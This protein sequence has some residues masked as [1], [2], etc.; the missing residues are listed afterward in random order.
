[1]QFAQ[2]NEFLQYVTGRTAARLE[3]PNARDTV[4]V[5]MDDR[6]LPLES[7][8]TGI[9]EVVIL[10][11][12]ATL[13][14]GE[15]VCIE[16]P[17]IHLHPVLQRKLLQ[18]LEEKTENQYLIA[19]H[20]AHLLDHPGAAVFH[21]R[22]EDRCSHVRPA[23]SPSERSEI[24]VDLG[25]RASDLLQANCVIWVE[26]PS[27]RIYLAH[28]LEAEAPHLREGVHYSIMF[29]GGRLLS[30]LTAE[31]PEVNEFISLRRL[32]RFIAVLMDS[33]RRTRWTELSDTKKRM[34]SEF[35][36]GPGFAWVTRGREIENYIPHS[37]LE[38]AVRACHRGV[39]EVGDT[40]EFRRALRYRAGRRKWQVADKVKV[41]HF[42]AS[43]AAE[44]DI[45]DLREMVRRTVRF[46]EEA[47]AR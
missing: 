29:Y 40:G 41:A 5:D 24:C 46:I 37:L 27:D 31:D 18:Y 34:Q 7:L 32:N 2:L 42:V 25:Y 19:T 12:E 26:G 38:E 35:D 36:K 39:T 45:L 28:W 3:I 11:A 17:E 43:Q 1:M 44:L 21:V 10:A 15:L 22:L 9:H 20:S 14:T 8:G 30:H 47:N 6:I 4:L 16:E 13:R 33:D 23:N